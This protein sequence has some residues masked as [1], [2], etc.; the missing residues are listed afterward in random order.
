MKGEWIR[1]FRALLPPL[2]APWLL[3]STRHACLD[4]PQWPFRPFVGH[5]TASKQLTT[6]DLI[7]KTLRFAARCSSRPLAKRRVFGSPRR[8]GTVPHSQTWGSESR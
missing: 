1:E 7:P 8:Q 3:R 4:R 5:L 6:P 2:R